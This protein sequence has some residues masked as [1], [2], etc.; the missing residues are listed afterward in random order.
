[1]SD[2]VRLLAI[3]RVRIGIPVV[4]WSFVVMNMFHWMLIVGERLPFYIIG[5]FDLFD[6]LVWT[7]ITYTLFTVIDRRNGPPRPRWQAISAAVV[8]LSTLGLT[9]IGLRSLLEAVLMKKDF[10]AIWLGYFPQ[11]FYNVTF[12]LAIVAGTGYGVRFWALEEQRRATAAQLE[13]AMTRAELRA[14]A[15]KLQPEVVSQSLSR[16]SAI[17]ASDPLRAQRLLVALGGVLHESLSRGTRDMVTVEEEL[18][19]VE[20]S[21][22]F[23]REMLSGGLHFTVDADADVRSLLV[24]CFTVHT[25]VQRTLRHCLEGGRDAIELRIEAVRD[26]DEVRLAVHESDAAS[27]RENPPWRVELTVPAEAA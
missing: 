16:I 15:G 2:S 11:G 14:A 10:F 3:R 19:S 6:G 27:D 7:A 12:Y 18:E 20:R 26:G 21:L 1:M 24:P 23:Q 17:L 8:L 9:I 4:V 25:L 22:A 5:A 13:A